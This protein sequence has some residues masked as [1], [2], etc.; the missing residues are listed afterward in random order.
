MDAWLSHD[1]EGAAL[2]RAQLDEVKVE[3]SCGYG[4]GSIGFV[5]AD[6]DPEAAGEGLE[7]FDVDA[8]IVDD[9]KNVVGGMFLLLRPGPRLHDVDVFSL[10]DDPIAEL[11]ALEHVVWF[12]RDATA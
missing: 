2:L 11:P 10:R 12:T 4:C 1:V 7:Q 3:S 8:Q 5:F 9:E 6:G